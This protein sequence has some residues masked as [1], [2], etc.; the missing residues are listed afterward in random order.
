MA[1]NKERARQADRKLVAEHA[2]LL[3][4][5]RGSVK[6]MAEREAEVQGRETVMEV[7]EVVRVEAKLRRRQMVKQRL[8]V[9]GG[10]EERMDVD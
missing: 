9:G 4:R 5:V 1:G 3:P 7:E 10:V 6:A 8:L 2:H